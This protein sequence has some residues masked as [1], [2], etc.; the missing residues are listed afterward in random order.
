[1]LHVAQKICQQFGS[2]LTRDDQHLRVLLDRLDQKLLQ[3]Q[4]TFKLFICQKN[5]RC[6]QHRALAG[7]IIGKP[8]GC[9]AV[10]IADAARFQTGL[11]PLRIFDCNDAL[12]ANRLCR[13][14]NVSHRPCIRYGRLHHALQFR[15]PG[16]LRRS[17]DHLAGPRD[18]LQNTLA[19]LHGVC[20]GG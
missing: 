14:Q 8:L 4:N 17:P 20:P 3:R 19:Q 2:K 9:V 1:M 11:R 18:A 5:I 6:F 13:I 16:R 15:L 7:R 12:R 10:V